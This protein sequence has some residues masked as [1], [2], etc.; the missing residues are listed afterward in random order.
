MSSS[1]RGGL[2]GGLEDREVV[3]RGIQADPGAGHRHLDR[4][5]DGVAELSEPVDPGDALIGRL[6]P[7]AEAREMVGQYRRVEQ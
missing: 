2:P 3:E 5:E 6:D 4:R 7:L 1:D